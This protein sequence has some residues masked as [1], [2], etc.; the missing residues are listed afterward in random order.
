[1]RTTHEGVVTRM[2]KMKITRSEETVFILKHTLVQKTICNIMGC[3]DVRSV[4][5]RQFQFVKNYLKIAL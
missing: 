2:P 4:A 5:M 1:M 3:N